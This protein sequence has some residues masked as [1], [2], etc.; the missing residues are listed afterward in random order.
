MNVLLTETWMTRLQAKSGKI[1]GAIIL[2][3]DNPLAV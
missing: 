2:S 1:R 3:V